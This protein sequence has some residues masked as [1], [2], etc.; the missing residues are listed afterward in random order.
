MAATR[1]AARTATR[2]PAPPASACSLGA[3][4]L[5]A[6]GE[7]RQRPH[8]LPPGVREAVHEPLLVCGDDVRR[9][10]GR[11]EGV[12]VEH[13]RHLGE[14][15]AHPAQRREQARGADLRDGIPPVAR[16]GVDVGGHEHP[17][18]VV[19]A[20]GAR[21]EAAATGD[22]TDRQ[23]VVRLGHGVG[24]HEEKTGPSTGSK[25]KTPSSPHAAVAGEG[26]C[27]VAGEASRPH[28]RAR[29]A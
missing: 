12:L 19:E 15:H 5:G 9:R 21:G 27:R 3:V 29:V 26:V 6:L 17:L 14:R 4:A 10:T 8:D 16:H 23:A 11:P 7:E 13:E 25:V 2:R 22:L 28:R 24:G 18:A 20:Q 1:S